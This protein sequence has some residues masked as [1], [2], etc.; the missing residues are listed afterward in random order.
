M[1]GCVV[2]DA[3]CADSGV[4]A[5][6]E[7]TVVLFLAVVSEREMSVVGV[8]GRRRFDMLVEVFITKVEDCLLCCCGE[9]EVT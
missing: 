6:S 1:S 4:M 8:V 7:G 2:E 9:V 3:A 5:F